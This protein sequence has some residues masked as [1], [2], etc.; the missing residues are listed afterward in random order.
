MREIDPAF[1]AAERVWRR[2]EKR[3]AQIDDG[4][5]IC[6]P[7][8]FRLQVS[9]RR[10]K[11]GSQ[12]G[13]TFGKFNGI[14]ESTVGELATIRAGKAFAVCVDDP[15]REDE[16][17]A[18]AALVMRPDDELEGSEKNALRELLCKIFRVIV[19]PT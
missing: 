1:A 17:H 11:H 18:L 14:A 8:A 19:P 9:L 10:E 7:S 12:D 15:Q 5:W 3:N 6:K 4:R 13:L 2:L 16:G